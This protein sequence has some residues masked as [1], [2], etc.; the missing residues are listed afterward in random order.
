ME[1]DEEL[2]QIETDEKKSGIDSDKIK[3]K[4]ARPRV[5]KNKNVLQNEFD[6]K[7]R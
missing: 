2:Q 7:K 4:M 3:K 6:V 1:I 5:P